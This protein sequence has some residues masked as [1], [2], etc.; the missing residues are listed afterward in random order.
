MYEIKI[1]QEL[2]LKTRM[3]QGMLQVLN[4]EQETMKAKD[5]HHMEA[6]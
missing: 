5:F 4:I 2:N 1:K 3:D 6:V